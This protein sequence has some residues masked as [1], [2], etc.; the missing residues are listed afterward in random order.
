MRLV[1][2]RVAT[3]ALGVLALGGLLLY[4]P[5]ASACEKLDTLIRRDDSLSFFLASPL[6]RQEKGV[7][8]NLSAGRTGPDSISPGVVVL[9]PWIYSADCKPFE[10]NEPKPWTPPNRVA[11]YT[12]VLR[13]SGKW[14]DNLPTFDV[15]DAWAQPIY[16][17]EDDARRSSSLKAFLT[18]EE[19]L[20]LYALVPTFD[21]LRERLGPN[22][23]RAVVERVE[24]W[25]AAHPA[26]AKRYPA[27]I[28]L[29]YVHSMFQSQPR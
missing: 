25:A 17:G 4:V 26:L 12:G 13:P 24:A 8:A 27:D 5:S 16:E 23:N 1:V 14:I 28:L 2:N 6:S 18:V 15:Y 29:D 10:W 9:V 3:V 22:S 20:D 7:R 19:F 21:E 11:F